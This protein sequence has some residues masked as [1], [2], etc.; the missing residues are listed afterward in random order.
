MHLA[1]SN[2]Y[3]HLVRRRWAAVNPADELDDE[4]DWSVDSDSSD[5][6]CLE[7]EHV[8]A[9]DRATNTQ[10]ERLLVLAL[11]PWGLR[12]SEVA[13][14]HT[15]QFVRDVP[16]DTAPYIEFEERRNGPGE[17]SLLYGHDVLEGHLA[18][19]S[20]AEDGRFLFPLPHATR[21]LISRWTVWNRFGDL[22]ERAD[23]P[24][25]IDGVSPTPKLARRFW[26]DAYASSL[27]VV[28]DSLGDVAAE[29]GSAS[30]EV[31]L[32]NYLSATRAGKLRQE[33]MREQ[34]ADAFE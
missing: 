11:C 17:V 24:D 21:N 19:D 16:R 5:T 27:N 9:L 3:A 32:Q 30:P 8:R 22:A 33:Y 25:D 28:L 15:R 12:P 4:F 34:L 29:Q 20:D 10:T 18:T 6:P 14:L 26:Y 1:V 2:W 23:L 13:R 7:S 31:V